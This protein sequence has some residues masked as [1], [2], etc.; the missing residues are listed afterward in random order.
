MSKAEL[1]TEVN[2][3]TFG[4][5]D[6][7]VVA[8][9]EKVLVSKYSSHSVGTDSPWI[10]AFHEF[11]ALDNA[12]ILAYPFFI[13]FF[14]GWAWGSALI[15]VFG[16]ISYY[17]SFCLAG[18]HEYGGK[19]NIRLRDLTSAILGRWT[20]YPVY[21]LQFSNLIFGNIGL[22]I[23]GG[24]CLK[25]VHDQYSEN[26]NIKLTGWSAI[27]GGICAIF[28][29]LIPHLHHLRVYSAISIVLITIFCVIAIVIAIKD[30]RNP[31]VPVEYFLYG[32][33]TEKVFNALGVLGTVAFAYNNV[34]LPEIQATVRAPAVRNMR[35]TITLY[36]IFAM[37]LWI[38]L[39]FVGYW[40]YGNGVYPNMLSN[41]SG[42]KWAVTVAFVAAWLQIIVSVQIYGA[43]IY[44]LCDTSFGRM[45]E[46]TWSL[47]NIAV[48]VISRGLYWGL[49][50]FV[51]MLLPYFG[52][53]V[54][55]AGSSSV[56]PCIF[57]ATLAMTAIVQKDTMN[58]IRKGLHW[59]G[60]VLSFA[61]G[62]IAF[63]AA[64]RYVVVDAKNYHVFANISG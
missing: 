18:L 19:R 16:I 43:P 17:I 28:T 61:V 25:A 47:Y 14:T 35:K 21:I 7:A 40:A 2:D 55:L 3:G 33:Q 57:A 56:F 15:V 34:I 50:T 59:I 8:G 12:F 13:F 5:P 9:G 52:D 31:A 10:C 4:S 54:P 6:V 22:V 26:Q 45:G 30:G 60:A 1:D 58:P 42:P 29:F 37:S 20:Y 32:N 41:L 44:E 51:A 64:L 39:T 49:T 36:Y 27:T 24:Q 48:R 23:L 11:A 53:F 46:S 63:I 38:V 62:I